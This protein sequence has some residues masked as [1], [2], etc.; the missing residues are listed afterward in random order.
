MFSFFSFV[1]CKSFLVR[2]LMGLWMGC[3]TDGRAGVYANYVAGGA[4]LDWM[5]EAE[6]GEDG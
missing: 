1:P 2:L 4:C 6:M 3:G 5:G